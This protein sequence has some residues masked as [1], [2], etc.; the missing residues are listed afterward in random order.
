MSVLQGLATAAEGVVDGVGYAGL[1]GVMLVENV[2][3]PVP[4]EVVLPMVGTQVAAGQLL[5]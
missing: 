1:A 3:P 5:F 2:L 4:S